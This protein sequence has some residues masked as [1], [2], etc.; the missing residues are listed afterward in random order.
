MPLPVLR[1][2]RVVSSRPLAKKTFALTLAP[3][4]GEP[5]FTFT[6][7][8]WAMMHLLNPDGTTWGKAAFSIASAPY[9]SGESFELAIKVYGD[10]TAKAQDLKPGDTVK[11]QGPYGVFTL[12]DGSEPLILV[13]GGIGVTPFRSMIRQSLHTRPDRSIVLFYSNRTREDIAYESEFRDLAAQY[14]NFR[15]V[16]LLTGDAPPDWDGERGRLD[17]RIFDAHVGDLAW[18]ECLMCGPK[19][20]MDSLKEILVAKGV[21]VKTKLRKELFS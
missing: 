20:M 16:F 7:G 18:C 4:D 12:R 19:A 6:A 15:P 17:A 3:A 13:A 21:D 11:I 14:P 2:F 10:Y 8:Q 1:P 9:E 5:M